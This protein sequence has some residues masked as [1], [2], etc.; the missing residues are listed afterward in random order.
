MVL[1]DDESTGVLNVF[2]ESNGGVA[3]IVLRNVG[4]RNDVKVEELSLVFSVLSVSLSLSLGVNARV[5]RVIGGKGG[6]LVNKS[7]L[8]I[9]LKVLLPLCPHVKIRPQR[10]GTI[11]IQPN[12]RPVVLTKFNKPKVACNVHNRVPHKRN[13]RDVFK[14]KS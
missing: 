10:H 7:L 4:M 11:I 14:H 3:I 9:G 1:I 13:G 12:S 5:S 2:A 8:I 6:K